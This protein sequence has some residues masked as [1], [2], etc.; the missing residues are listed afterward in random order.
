MSSFYLLIKTNWIS[1]SSFQILKN[2]STNIFILITTVWLNLFKQLIKLIFEKIMY[3]S[4][5]VSRTDV[6]YQKFNHFIFLN[7]LIH[8]IV[9]INYKTTNRKSYDITRCAFTKFFFVIL[10]SYR[11]I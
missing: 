3:I 10:F 9:C 4:I 2:I 11:T 5:F 7:A 8:L 6:Q 1:L